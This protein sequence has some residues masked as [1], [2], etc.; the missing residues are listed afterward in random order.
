MRGIKVGHIAYNHAHNTAYNVKGLIAL[1]YRM[2]TAQV[3]KRRAPANSETFRVIRVVYKF[4]Y[5]R[6]ELVTPFKCKHAPKHTLISSWEFFLLSFFFNIPLYLKNLHLN[7][8]FNPKW[9]QL[10]VDVLL[11]FVH[12]W[13]NLGSL[14]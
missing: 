7:V 12:V 4:R 11:C 13:E 14:P 3:V 2:L 5:L 6:I 10:E 9:T 8:K 1:Y